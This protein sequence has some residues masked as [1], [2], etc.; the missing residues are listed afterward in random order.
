MENAAENCNS[1]IEKVIQD[2]K[3]A[4][5]DNDI[6]TSYLQFLEDKNEAV[7]YRELSSYLSEKDKYNSMIQAQLL[8][9][10]KKQQW[11][12]IRIAMLRERLMQVFQI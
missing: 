6:R 1:N 10:K 5:Y 7:M 2:S 9:L 11:N 3:Q 4:S 12:I 8:Y